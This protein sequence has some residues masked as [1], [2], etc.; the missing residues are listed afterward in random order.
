MPAQKAT[1]DSPR[2]HSMRSSPTALA[3]RISFVGMGMRGNLANS[4]A[5][6]EATSPNLRVQAKAEA[7][8]TSSGGT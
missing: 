1:G 6:L 2:T 4:R 8:I 7:K 3:V 5:A